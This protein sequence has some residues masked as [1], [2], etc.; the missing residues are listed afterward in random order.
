MRLAHFLH[1]VVLTTL[2]RK[3][4]NAMLPTVY[5]CP[6]VVFL[7]ENSIGIIQI[8]TALR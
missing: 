2:C 3:F 6:G 8:A 7:G 4:M 5:F 1:N